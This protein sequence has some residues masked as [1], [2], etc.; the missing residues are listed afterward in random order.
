HAVHVGVERADDLA[1]LAP[2][3]RREVQDLDVVPG[4]DRLRA[5]GEQAVGRLV[6]VGVQVAFVVALGRAL[7]FREGWLSGGGDLPRRRVDKRDTHDSG[8]NVSRASRTEIVNAVPGA[9]A[10]FY[11][12]TQVMDEARHVEAYDRYLREK[13]ETTFPISPYLRTLL[14]EILQ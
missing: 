11:A 8:A 2:R 9:D 14:D 7:P 13:I 12:A 6:E 10:K 3:V 1:E 4:A 5:D